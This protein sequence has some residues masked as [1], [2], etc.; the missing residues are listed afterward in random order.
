MPQ[1]TIEEEV[2]STQEEQAS[3]SNDELAALRSELEAFRQ[4]EQTLAAER[5]DFKRRFEERDR[6]AQKVVGRQGTELGELRKKTHQLEEMLSQVLNRPEK[7]KKSRFDDE[8]IVPDPVVDVDN[9]KKFQSTL[10]GQV[11][12]LQ[13]KL[14]EFQ[15][16]GAQSQLAE[17]KK[18]TDELNALKYELYLTKVEGNMRTEYGFDD[19]D[20]E[21]LHDY[22]R[23]TGVYDPEQAAIKLP[24]LKRKMFESQLKSSSNGEE[25]KAGNKK[26]DPVKAGNEILKTASDSVP[27]G[28]GKRESDTSMSWRSEMDTAVKDGTFFDWP[29]TKQDEY[30]RK[31]DIWLR[32][33]A[34]S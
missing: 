5:D 12:E 31:L 20:F 2:P 26:F 34:G 8:L 24:G 21:Q 13:A 29:K 10:A 18:V 6:E 23:D 14:D 27:R 1:A 32:E 30:R 7:E 15:T 25:K 11:N 17:V 19:R 22:M 4:K 9:F 16:T 33:S 28:G 3:D